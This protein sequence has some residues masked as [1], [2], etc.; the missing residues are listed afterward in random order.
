MCL[1]LSG[2]FCVK[3]IFYHPDQ[4][5]F[6][7]FFKKFDDEPDRVFR[8]F[9]P[10]HQSID[11]SELHKFRGLTDLEDVELANDAVST[12]SILIIFVRVFVTAYQSGFPFTI[13]EPQN[14]SIS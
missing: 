1:D 10:Q 11:I 6:I 9:E 5:F 12:L 2:V 8:K 7:S 4:T 3:F 14:P 13:L